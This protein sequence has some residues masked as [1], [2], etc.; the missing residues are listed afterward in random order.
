MGTRNLTIVIQDGQPKV[1]QY[2]Q[3]DG[4]PDGQGKTVLEFLRGLN[5]TRHISFAANVARCIPLDREEIQRRWES[6]GADKSGF[7]SLDIAGNFN[8]KWPQLGRDLGAKVLQ[9]IADSKQPVEVLLDYD[10]AADSLFCE[11]AY[12]IDL[13]KGMLEVYKGFNKRPLA[14]SARFHSLTPSSAKRRESPYYPIRLKAK[15][16][17]TKL[18]SFKAFKE[19]ID[20]PE[21]D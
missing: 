8:A 2:C 19:A 16:P 3:W 20:L 4:Y 7:V 10:F 15:W 9:L 18:P 17:L 1:A 13:D 6:V 14:K 21:E 12:V 11:Y 5:S